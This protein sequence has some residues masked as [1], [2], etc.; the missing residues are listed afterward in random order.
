MYK[1]LGLSQVLPIH[2]HIYTYTKKKRIGD[3]DKETDYRNDE[4][5]ERSTG[6]HYMAIYSHIY[7]QIS[8]YP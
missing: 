1:V 6:I 5:I 2:T 8:V 7:I 4:T 3:N